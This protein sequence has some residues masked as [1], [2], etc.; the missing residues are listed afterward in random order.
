MP[1]V[2]EASVL[3]ATRDRPR[4]L[5]RCVQA[6]LDGDV[7]P[8]Q[9]IVV[10]QGAE[11]ALSG[12]TPNPGNPERVVL[13]DDG[14][15]LSR[16]RNLALEAARCPVAAVID[17]DCVPTPR[18]LASIIEALD[19]EPVADCICG[20][21][22]PLPPEGMKRYPTST[23]ASL[24]AADYQGP[25]VPW[26][27]GT[28]GNFAIRTRLA[29]RLGGYDPRLGA[30]SPSGAS[31]DID[32]IYRVLRAGARIRYA[33]AALVHHERADAGRRRATRSS[34]GRGIGAFIGTHLRAGDLRAAALLPRWL[35]QR[36]GLLA[37]AAAHADREA[38]AE[39]LI[40]MRATCGGLVHGLRRRPG[41][42]SS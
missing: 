12:L 22:L 29:R 10:D 37:R 35:L 11:P 17:D 6:I 21:V 28:G 32:L 3:I 23:R 1:P 27:V 4:A 15:G 2:V 19:R 9:I 40:V 42:E 26:Q 38:M 30:G 34:Y 20:P 41:R 25:A 33:P 5:E 18:W 13:R 31:E 36:A 16:A 14:I 8:R 7:W 39:E 24:E